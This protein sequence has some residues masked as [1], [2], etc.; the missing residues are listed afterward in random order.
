MWRV[1]A[2]GWRHTCTR[3]TRVCLS[4]KLWA[5]RVGLR[6]RLPQ[7]PRPCCAFLPPLPAAPPGHLR[8]PLWLPIVFMCSTLPPFRRPGSPRCP[9]PPRLPRPGQSR[10]H[11][12]RISACRD[13]L[14]FT[15]TQDSKRGAPPPEAQPSEAQGQRA[16]RAVLQAAVLL[17]GGWLLGPAPRGCRAYSSRGCTLHTAE[18]ERESAR[19]PNPVSPSPSPCLRGELA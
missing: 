4:W 7:L 10:R 5:L 13:P 15:R 11:P 8:P 17:A 16:M 12:A 6:P 14:A 2:G 1:S 9:P 19:R 3:A 18:S